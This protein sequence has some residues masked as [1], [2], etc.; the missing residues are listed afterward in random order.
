LLIANFLSSF[1]LF[2]TERLLLNSIFFL[3]VN[4]IQIHSNNIQ[5]KSK[6]NFRNGLTIQLK[7]NLNPM[8]FGIYWGLQVLNCPVFFLSKPWNSR[9]NIFLSN[10]NL[11]AKLIVRF[12][13]IKSGLASLL[14]HK[15]LWIFWLKN[16]AS[17]DLDWNEKNWIVNHNLMQQIGL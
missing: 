3:I 1:L 13:K 7:S 9:D 14:E 6:S 12:L 5:I 15:A 2:P 8:I 17:L 11:S 16:S 10:Y 4:L